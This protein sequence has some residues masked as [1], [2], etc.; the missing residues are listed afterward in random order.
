V[1]ILDHHLQEKNRFLEN[2]TLCGLC[3]EGCP[4]L[5]YTDISEIS[6]QDIQKAVFDFMHSGIPNHVAYTKA[7]ACMEC[8]KC[9]AGMCPENLNP[10]L[11]NELIKAQYISK[12]LA[13]KAYSD[14]RQPDSAHRVLASVQ[15]SVSEYNR[16]TTSSAQQAAR[17]VFFPGCNVYFQPEKILNALD[18]M[19]AIGDDYAFLPGLDYCCGD[20]LLFLGEIDEGIKRAEE[21]V[22]AIASFQ[23]E[24]AVLWCPTCQCRFDNSIA[25]AMDIP[26]KIL[27]F[28]QYLAANMSK[29]LLTRAAAG[30][31]TLHEACKSAYTGVDRDGP[32]EVLRQLPGITLSEMEHHGQETV[33][34]GSGAICW[35]PESCAQIRESRLQEAAQTGAGRLVT[36][37][38]YCNQTL[39]AEECHYDFSVTNYVNLVAEAVGIRRDD[40]FRQYT[41]WGDLERILRDAGD[42]IAGSPFENERIMEVLQAVFVE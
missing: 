15:V 18:I 37:C 19:D 8:F 35:F 29:L 20:G 4:I 16:I 17:Y 7:F 26:F 24:A 28:P 25:P 13:S 3:A 21:L 6:S 40:T 14:A 10:M 11:V 31:V 36:V 34:C 5:P 33:C 42:R 1:T 9:T 32:R 30:T 22:A 23:P 27:S 39:V 38:H 41:L 2:C 12:G